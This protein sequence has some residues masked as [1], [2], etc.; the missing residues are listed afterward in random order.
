V[1]GLWVEG[2]DEAARC[3]SGLDSAAVRSPLDSGSLLGDIWLGMKK[4]ETDALQEAAAKIAEGSSALRDRAASISGAASEELSQLAS[5]AGASA[6][7]LRALGDRITE[8]SRLVADARKK[9][10]SAE[11]IARLEE[12]V[13][14]AVAEDLRRAMGQAS[15]LGEQGDRLAGSLS[16]GSDGKGAG[17]GSKTVSEA[18]ATLA[19][20]ESAAAGAAEALSRGWR[21]TADNFASRLTRATFGEKLSIV[22]ID[23]KFADSELKLLSALGGGE[24]ILMHLEP[25]Y[26][27]S[28]RATVEASKAGASAP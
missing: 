28:L 4:A 1:D 25:A 24:A 16:S 19:A 8:A 11:E 9:G 27:A 3:P 13:T 20:A 18:V 2:E 26:Y 5:A 10:A 7:E 21:D 14:S 6:A 23:A 15:S 22:G 12:N 17:L